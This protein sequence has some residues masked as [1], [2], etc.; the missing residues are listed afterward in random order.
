MI[1]HAIVLKNYV[2]YKNKVTILHEDFGK[3]TIFVQEKDL[4]ARLCNGALF[5]CQIIKKQ[6]KNKYQVDF[7]DPYFI[8]KTDF[9][10]IHD[11]LKICL[12]FLPDEVMSREIFDYIIEIYNNLDQLSVCQKKLSLLKL[13]LFVG[14][15]PENKKMY[16]HV[17]QNQD[18]H[19]CQNDQLLAEGLS[20]CWNSENSFAEGKF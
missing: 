3:I 10:F 7:V 1:F 8:P 9:Y 19:S 5:Y 16:Q 14:I 17:M 18:L 11:I 4:A 15:F 13:F 6:N 20:Y 12:Q 2:P